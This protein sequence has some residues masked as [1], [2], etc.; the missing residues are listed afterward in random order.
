MRELPGFLVNVTC[1]VF[2]GLDG[3]LEWYDCA[4]LDW[5]SADAYWA[6]ILTLLPIV[7]SVS[8]WD[9]LMNSCRIISRLWIA[10]VSLIT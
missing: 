6:S 7:D 3:F 5:I 2:G 9:G 10:L 4:Q 8:R 1:S